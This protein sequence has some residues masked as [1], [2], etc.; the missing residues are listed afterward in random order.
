M[1]STPDVLSDAVAEMAMLLMLG[2]A[3]RVHDGHRMLYERKWAG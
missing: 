3:R 1:L 2:A